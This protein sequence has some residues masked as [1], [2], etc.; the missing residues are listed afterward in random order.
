MYIDSGVTQDIDGHG[1]A[2]ALDVLENG[3]ERGHFAGMA[4]TITGYEDAAN[5]RGL[6]E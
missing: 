5:S 1:I 4:L 3:L 2:S 6:S